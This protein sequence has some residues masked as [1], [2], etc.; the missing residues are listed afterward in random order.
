MTKP[1]YTPLKDSNNEIR[2]FEVPAQGGD[3]WTLI[4]DYIAGPAKVKIEVQD[5]DN[6]LWQYATD[7]YCGPGGTAK[8]DVGALLPTAPIGALIGKVGGSSA[9]CPGPLVQGLAPVP[10]AG[11]PKMF[12][13]GRFAVIKLATED[14]GPLF[15]AMNDLL[16]GF[17]QHSGKI[18]VTVSTAA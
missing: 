11:S 14:S 15:L 2:I 13:V 17:P 18:K 7:H 4:D 9:D 6:A 3:L 10:A 1:T 5:P 12:T 16:S 8:N